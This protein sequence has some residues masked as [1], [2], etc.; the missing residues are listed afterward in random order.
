[1]TA[2]STEQR[3]DSSCAFLKRPPFRFKKVLLIKNAGQPDPIQMSYAAQVQTYTE[4]LRSSLIAL[5]SIFL[6]PMIAAEISP[7]QVGRYGDLIT[8]VS[9]ETSPTMRI[10]RRLYVYQCCR[11]LSLLNP[12]RVCFSGGRRGARS[13]SIA[14]KPHDSR[15]RNA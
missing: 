11:P 15:D 1:M 2:T 14:P 4:R 6:R 8:T 7:D 12:G 5:I 9:I 13:S 10:F 3:T